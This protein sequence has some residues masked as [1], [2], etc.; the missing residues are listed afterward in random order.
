MGQ[1]FV[2]AFTAA[3]NPTLLAAVTVMLALE[4][5]S[6]LLLGYL[7][8]AALTS[9]A[10]GLVLVFVLSS[11]STSST[12]KHTVN[13]ALNVALGVLLLALVIVIGTGRDKRRRA[14]SARRRE[15]AAHK[16]PPR[17]RRELSKGSPRTTFVVGVL[18]T[19]PGA[20]Q[21]AGMDLLHKQHL[22]TAVTVVS[23]LAF[24]AIMLLL[25]ELPVIGYAVAP[26]WTGDAVTRF[27]N[28]LSR[29]SG[30]IGL[31]LGGT[32]SILLIV[33]GIVNW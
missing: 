5:P 17:W 21:I 10:C 11:S 14:W 30:R 16:P 13:P 26:E 33:R 27:S 23:V 6:R 32:F 7:A 12:A 29:S 9:T 25:L 28:W 8:G 2:F 24:N 31:V 19:F 4:R 1:V 3:L 20:S 18:L 15:K 22:A